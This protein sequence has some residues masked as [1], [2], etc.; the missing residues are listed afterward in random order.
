MA[1]RSSATLNQANNEAATQSHMPKD[2][3]SLDTI[4]DDT[5]ILIFGFLTV[6][7]VLAMRQVRSLS[8]Y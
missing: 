4:D 3:I 1:L 5:L 2:A 7:D 6:P 8:V